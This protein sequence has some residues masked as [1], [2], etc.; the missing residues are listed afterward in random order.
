MSEEKN[1]GKNVEVKFICRDLI[2]LKKVKMPIAI[3]PPPYA[4]QGR[5]GKVFYGRDI[6]TDEVRTRL[7]PLSELLEKRDDNGGVAVP[8]NDSVIDLRDQSPEQLRRDLPLLRKAG[9]ANHILADSS[10]Y[11]NK[12]DPS[13]GPSHFAW[14]E[15]LVSP[16]WK[17]QPAGEENGHTPLASQAQA[18]DGEQKQPAEEGW[19]SWLREHIAKRFGGDGGVLLRRCFVSPTTENA[20]KDMARLHEVTEGV[21]RTVCIP[22]LQDLASKLHAHGRLYAADHVLFLERLAGFLPPLRNKEG[23]EAFG[24]VRDVCGPRTVYNLDGLSDRLEKI[25]L[26]EGYLVPEEIDSHTILIRLPHPVI[27]YQIARMLR[28]PRPCKHVASYEDFLGHYDFIRGCKSAGG[29]S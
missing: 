7:R 10:F 2:T 18:C 1:E 24:W 14:A 28:H 13:D 12:V 5:M 21:W 17:T 27:A 6:V 9:F 19:G 20:R 26:L 23:R 15:Y 8:A 25:L 3:W 4:I 22:H 16:V 11:F 29:G